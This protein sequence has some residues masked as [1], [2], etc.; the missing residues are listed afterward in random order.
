MSKRE[1]TKPELEMIVSG[2]SLLS[3]SVNRQI[4]N[5]T[6]NEQL[7]AY[8]TNYLADITMLKNSLAN[9]ELFK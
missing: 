9:L 3:D 7:K 4:R 5:P 6:N 1:V 8:H 2:L